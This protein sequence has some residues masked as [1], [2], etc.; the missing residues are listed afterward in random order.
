MDLVSAKCLRVQNEDPGQW[1]STAG[2]EVQAGT[3]QDNTY[4]STYE[5]VAELLLK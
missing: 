1:L 2:T 4:P 5:N 3:K